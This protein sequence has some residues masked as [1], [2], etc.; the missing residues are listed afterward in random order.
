MI[1]LRSD[2]FNRAN[3]TPLAGNWTD[4]G[5]PVPFNL[6]GNV[7]VPSAPGANDSWA[8]YNAITWPDNQ[9]SSAVLTCTGTVGGGAGVG[10][11][12]RLS[13]NTGPNGYR[14]VI[15]HNATT[16]WTLSRFNSGVSSTLASGLVTF[17]DGDTFTLQIVTAG[18]NAFLTMF[19]GI[20]QFSSFT[21]T[22]PIASG[23]AGLAF[24]SNE[25]AA[26]IDN[27]VGGRAGRQLARLGV[28]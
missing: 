20:T 28:K 25:T 2:N 11:A 12:V 5:S 15:D 18:A 21:D 17:T 4:P 23:S 22:S 24:S 1:F 14:L 9:W 26:T 27:W 16:N 8:F 19:R 3:E 7:V 13:N 10:L 6:S